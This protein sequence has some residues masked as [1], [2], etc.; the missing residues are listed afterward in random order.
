MFKFNLPKNKHENFPWG[1]RCCYGHLK[2]QMNT[3][4]GT[5]N[6]IER[7]VGLKVEDSH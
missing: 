4:K 7:L 6:T 1:V 3:L 5:E 2:I